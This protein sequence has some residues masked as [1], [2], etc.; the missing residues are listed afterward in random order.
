M[1]AL[2]AWIS[3]QSRGVP[4]AVPQKHAKEKQAYE[5]GKQLFFY[6]A[7]PYDFS[8]AT[9]HSQ[10]NKRIRLQNLP[11]LL[12]TASAKS[13]FSTWPGYRISQGALRTIEWRMGDCARQQR[14]PQ[15]QFGSDAAIALIT[16]MGVQAKGEPMAAPGLK[17]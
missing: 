11:N 9:C 4:I 1:E 8:C 2:A 13:A 7:G 12:D 17:R 15:L 6:R 3:G 14:L 5:I 10:A 16:Y